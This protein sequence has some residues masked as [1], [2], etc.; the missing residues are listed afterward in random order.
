[1]TN[2]TLSELK[3]MFRSHFSEEYVSQSSFWNEASLEG[4]RV[5]QFFEGKRW[6]DISLAVL[7]SGYKGDASACLSFMSVAGAFYYLPAYL[8]IIAEEYWAADMVADSVLYEFANILPSSSSVMQA[9]QQMDNAQRAVI[10]AC[11][12]YIAD[13]YENGG[14]G[15]GHDALRCWQSQGT[16]LP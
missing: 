9:L 10:S 6:T 3:T 8:L 13:T 16:H 4:Q 7:R 11:L 12:G 14:A 5:K 2:A 15:I 1:M